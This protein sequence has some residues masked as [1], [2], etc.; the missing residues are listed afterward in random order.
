MS[1]GLAPSRRAK[2]ERTIDS[3]SKLIRPRLRS[4]PAYVLALV[5]VV[6]GSALYAVEVLKLLNALG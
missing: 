1:D 5:W 4:R 6:V 3:A 2:V